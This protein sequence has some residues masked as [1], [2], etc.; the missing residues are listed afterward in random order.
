MF[1]NT[2]ISFITVIILTCFLITDTLFAQQEYVISIQTHKYYLINSEDP[3]KNFFNLQ[4]SFQDI[5]N[6]NLNYEIQPGIIFADPAIHLDFL[7]NYKM[8]TTFLKGG[9][10]TYLGFSGGGNSGTSTEVY[11]LPIIG[12]G[13]N[14]GN[15][16]DIEMN[17][18]IVYLTL[19]LD[20]RCIF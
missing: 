10:M 2:F 12:L 1:R 13:I 14:L 16:F 6:G 20:Y 17:Y 5:L 15:H 11:L 8:H 19:G 9:V 18:T 3:L 7:F 4:F